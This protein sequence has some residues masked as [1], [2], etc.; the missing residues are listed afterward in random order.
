MSFI[1]YLLPGWKSLLTNKSSANAGILA[2]I[3]TEFSNT[4]TDIINSKSELSLDTADS[5]WLD[6]FGST[7]GVIR[8]NNETDS[9]YRTRIT[10]YIQT[11][12]GTI[13][14]ITQAVQQFLNNNAISVDVYEP[15]R[16]IFTLNSSNLNGADAFHGSYYTTAVIDIRIGAAVPAGLQDFINSYTP[17]GVTVILT[18]G[19]MTISGMITGGSKATANVTLT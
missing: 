13:P 17:A 1:K 9:A 10:N 15:Y 3:D 19:Y 5:D 14:S 2:A 16:N 8:Q 4:E 6:L 11:E 7:F 12:R 18:G